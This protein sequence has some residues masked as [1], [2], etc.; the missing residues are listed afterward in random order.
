[1]KRKLFSL[2]RPVLLLCALLLT[3]HPV[4]DEASTTVSTES[5]ETHRFGGPDGV[6]G[7][8]KRAYE[9]KD[10]AIETAILQSYYDWKEKVKDEQGF[11]FGFVGYWLGQKASESLS[12]EDS[13]LGQMYRVQGRWKLF[14]RGTG[15][16]GWIEY[17]IEHRS[18]IGNN[19]SPSELGG[20]IGAAALNSGYAYSPDFEWD[21]AVINWTQGFNDQTAGVAVGRLAY[22]VY[23]D[24]F[25]F[26]TFSKGFINRAFLVNP[27][28]G[29]DRDR[30]PGSGGERF[31][32]RSA[33]D[34]R[35]DL[36]W[37]CRER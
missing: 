15:H 16:P 20:E 3:G 4:A 35:T 22:D 6:Q 25:P 24:A 17:R 13:A 34:R 26:Q 28:P 19:L 11:S 2:Y 36:R 7:D 12:D 21:L 18:S 30:C 5:G 29:N 10:R 27:A 32:H 31:H 1:M 8:L 14:G 33:A 9:D 23:L 37:Q